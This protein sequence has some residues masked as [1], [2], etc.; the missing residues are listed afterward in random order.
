MVGF[1]AIPLAGLRRYCQSR[2]R[3]A[4]SV[5]Q[6]GDFVTTAEPQLARV[7]FQTRQFGAML[8]RF[9]AGASEAVLLA[10]VAG[11]MS[12]IPPLQH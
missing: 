4:T 1:I 7:A 6:S 8:A 10:F 2:H 3:G 9:E 5:P 11:P 12:P